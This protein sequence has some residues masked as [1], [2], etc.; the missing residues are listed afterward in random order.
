MFIINFIFPSYFSSAVGGEICGL[1]LILHGI[2]GWSDRLFLLLPDMPDIQL[3]SI[4]L[5]S[6]NA[7]LDHAW[8][9]VEHTSKSVFLT[10]KAGTGKTT[11]LHRVVS[12]STKRLVVVAPTGVAAINAG[13]VTIHSFFQLPFSPFIPGTN[14]KSKYEFR[15]EKLRIIRTLDLLIIDEISMVRSDLLDAIDFILRKLRHSQQP[16][17]G[18]QL[19]FIGDLQQLTPVVTHEEEALLRQHYATPY[20]FDSTAL[21]QVDYVTIELTHVYRQSDEHFV[22]LLNR[23]REGQLRSE[24]LKAL[25]E[26]YLPNFI[27]K[28]G[29]DFIRLTTHNASADRYNI[30][31]LDALSGD[32]GTYQAA[33]QGTFP[34]YAYPTDITLTLKVGAQVMFVKNDGAPYYRFYNGRIGHVT[35]L[36][37]DKV[38]VRCP[39]DDE[40]IE[41]EYE[42]WE[43]TK[44]TLNEQ[45][46]EIESE[47]QGRFL[48]LPLRLAWA[49][50]IHKSQ[51]LTFDH[52]VIEANRSFAPGQVYVALS[53]CRSLERLVLAEPLGAH[54]II[55]DHRVDR[56][57]ALQDEKA[58][59]SIEMLPQS[60]DDYV[61]TLLVECFTFTTLMQGMERLYKFIVEHLR[62]RYPQ[63]AYEAEQTYSKGN[64]TIQNVSWRWTQHI[65]RQSVATMGETAFAERTE[66]ALHYFRE[67]IETLFLPL[68]KKLAKVTIRNKENQKRKVELV[69]ECLTA[70]LAKVYL[71]EDIDGL[72]FSTELYLR[73]KQHALLDAMNGGRQQKKRG[74]TR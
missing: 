66:N 48:Q 42:T 23:V 65:A 33:L 29:D 41:V 36:R 47:V 24:D 60:K 73:A 55:N 34:E 70:S 1:C 20:F 8:D 50:T 6:D 27:P 62:S 3:T 51:G 49:I 46:Q 52:A 13:G 61:R 32:V 43:N 69:A 71:F 59:R 28:A 16:F 7:M 57:I 35:A 10:G 56:Y 37:D 67:Q 15:K 17:G 19:L 12:E 22:A 72:P 68:L 39:G 25:N 53:R 40:D 63:L 9:F 30:Q 18:V 2:C 21:R 14:M 74:A 5:S 4:S 54:A 44:Y 58:C 11:F 45:T 38:L 64:E 31:A 26:R